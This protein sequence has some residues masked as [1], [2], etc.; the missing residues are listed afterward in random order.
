MK[1]KAVK[2]AIL[3]LLLVSLFTTVVSI[4]QTTNGLPVHNVDTGLSY[5]TI[6]DA[7]NAPQTLGGHTIHVD[8]GLYPEHVTVGK[9]VRLVGEDRTNS[10]ID[11]GGTGTVV[12]VTAN[13][14]SVSGFT[15]RNS[16]SNLEDNGIRLTHSSNTVI[17]G[18]IVTG[19][20][21]GISLEYSL[22]NVINENTIQNS[23][24][25]G[26]YL[27][28]S[29]SNTIAGNTETD[30]RY[31]VWLERSSG[32]NIISANTVVNNDKGVCLALTANNNTVS[33]NS[34]TKNGDGIYLMSSFNT[35]VENNVTNNFYGIFSL[36]S[37]G[38]IIYRNNFIENP[39]QVSLNKS[40]ISTWDNGAEG[41]YWNDYNGQD[42]D[43]DGIGDTNLP[44]E[45]LDWHPLKEQWN[46][47][48]VFDVILEEEK[49]RVTTLSNSTI[50]SFSFNPSLKQISFNVTGPSEK[51][52]FC[53]VTVPKSLLR[54]SWTILL[55]QTN[56]TTSVSITE[57]ETQTF[58]YLNY[59]F[60]THK[61][62]IIGTDVLDKSPPVAN[63]GPDQTISEDQ[64]VTF[65]GSSSYDNIGITSYTWTFMD[66]TQQILT[67]VN[68]V[69]T[70]AN[71]GI[72]TIALNVSDGAGHHA[73]DTVIITVIDVTNPIADAGSDRT[74]TVNTEVSFSAS[75]SNDN[76][77]IVGYQWDFGDGTTGTGVTTIHAYTN[78]ETYTVTLTVRDAAN[79]TNT[80]SITVTV[81]SYLQ[82]YFWW[83][84][85]AAAAIVIVVAG[86]FIWKRK[87]RKKAT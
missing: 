55:D 10:I 69:Y 8:A 29:H 45:S 13:N 77:G 82:A 41:N 76:V 68:P 56:I 52:G 16:G 46:R 5:T 32:N 15:I 70:F 25:G 35:V 19:S 37:E 21:W 84:V 17:N 64:S 30:N 24:Y 78:P 50:A 44:Y 63:A 87:R 65:N 18:N 86:I 80:D 1:S 12:I 4:A 66:K 74:V 31:G 27:G 14:V 43:G 79:N 34:V 48:R 62:K 67:G 53:N 51:V 83:I 54:D 42:T 57:T 40:F 7:I 85:G 11:G 3:A 49:Y 2:K 61:V 59:G 23:G 73:A 36:R 28:D 39:T 33:N 26:V 58:F 75:G 81:L 9:S 60:S 22:N 71:P 20:T 38:N 72:Y 6:Q 47:F